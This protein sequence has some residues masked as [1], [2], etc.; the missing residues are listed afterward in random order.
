MKKFENILEAFKNI[1]KVK[2]NFEITKGIFS[3]II[4]DVLIVSNLIFTKGN[5][6][7][8]IIPFIREKDIT[9]IKIILENYLEDF[10][11]LKSLTIDFS[12]ITNQLNDLNNK[13]KPVI[14]FESIFKKNIIKN[15]SNIKF[16]YL[17]HY[18]YRF[19]FLKMTQDVVLL[20]HNEFDLR[21]DYI[22]MD[23]NQGNL[24]NLA[25]KMPYIENNQIF[26]I[27]PAIELILFE[28]V[29]AQENKE[30]TSKPKTEN[31][32]K[33]LHGNVDNNLIQHENNS[34]HYE[35]KCD[36]T[37]TFVKIFLENSDVK[38]KLYTNIEKIDCVE[39][40]KN[41]IDK[42]YNDLKSIIDFDNSYVFL[43]KKNV[44]FDYV[45]NLYERIAHICEF[46]KIFLI[47]CICDEVVKL[48]NKIIDKL[49]TAN[50]NFLKLKDNEYDF[51]IST[52]KNKLRNEKKAIEIN[53]I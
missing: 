17:M 49:T 50:Y 10:N 29:F 43:I 36:L 3:E 52:I 7:Q 2:K 40:V 48:Y 6:K 14:I 35:K 47:D 44:T 24:K 42:F 53:Q 41:Y 39:Y 5:L 26:I 51:G 46:K 30:Y 38:G 19:L 27:D 4:A 12:S 9:K 20:K 1:D 31:I 11:N 18:C 8:A 32:I 37:A 16:I 22:S 23:F 34:N 45:K 25:Q 13:T 21:H 33:N 28:L 15:F